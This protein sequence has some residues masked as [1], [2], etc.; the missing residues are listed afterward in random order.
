MVRFGKRK[1]SESSLENVIFAIGFA[2]MLIGSIGFDLDGFGVIL[3]FAG[4]MVL[5][6]SDDIAKSISKK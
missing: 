5:A 2:S 4:T 3:F 6:F 1:N